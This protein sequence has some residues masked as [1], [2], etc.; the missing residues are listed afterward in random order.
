MIQNPATVIGNFPSDLSTMDQE[1]SELSSELNDGLY[2][3]TRSYQQD[4]SGPFEQTPMSSMLPSTNPSAI[5]DVS[6]SQVETKSHTPLEDAKRKRSAVWASE[7][8]RPIE[9]KLV[10]ALLFKYMPKPTVEDMENISNDTGYPLEFVIDSYR[11]NRNSGRASDIIL[12]NNATVGHLI[13]KPGL[14]EA[15]NLNNTRDSAYGPQIE[16][17]NFAQPVV[18][19]ARVQNNPDLPATQAVDD[20]CQNKFRRC[21]LCNQGF[22][23]QAELRRHI[24]THYPGEF[25]CQYPGCGMPFTRKDHLNNHYER[26]HRDSSSS[27]PQMPELRLFLHET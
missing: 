5:V 16:R 11:Q 13:S 23:R 12:S 1:S 9:G 7:E 17:K 10:L 3:Y 15:Q 4:F 26:K 18:K 8:V 24:K 6:H 2:G 22:T 25:H 20:S 27:A 14:P 19:R 21:G